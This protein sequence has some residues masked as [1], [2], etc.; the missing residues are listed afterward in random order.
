MQRGEIE[1]GQV[2]TI[3]RRAAV[4]DAARAEL[5]AEEKRHDKRV[6]I[7]SLKANLRQ[8]RGEEMQYLREQQREQ[9]QLVRY[10]GDGLSQPPQ[11]R[12]VSDELSAADLL[13]EQ[14]CSKEIRE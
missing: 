7:A 14:L 2:D 3:L 4:T 11:D 1:Q 6:S 10:S 5:K 9:E 8:N 13:M 12:P